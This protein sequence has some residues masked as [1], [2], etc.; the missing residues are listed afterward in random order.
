[1]SEL[2]D[3]SRTPQHA[4]HGQCP[5]WSR[6]SVA[7]L[8]VAFYR[9]DEQ[10]PET[11]PHS[12][13]ATLILFLNP[14]IYGHSPVEGYYGDG[15]DYQL[16]DGTAVAPENIIAFGW[17]DGQPDWMTAASVS[18]DAPPAAS[19]A[20][21]LDNDAVDRFAAALKA[22]LA[23]KRAEGYGGWHDT[24][25]CP[26]GRLAAQLR[27]HV[28]KGDP[29]DVGNLAM[30]LWSRGETTNEHEPAT[31]ERTERYFLDALDALL[32]AARQSGFILTT[33]TVPLQPLAMGH[34]RVVAQIRPARQPTG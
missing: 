4:L 9:P 6:S 33:E 28:R 10:T 19:S 15:P 12:D 26:A 27:D 14:S 5:P 34:Y 32:G 29:V 31:H 18:G 30:M 3:A 1:M 23:A 7:R 2:L 20:E 25:T 13:D 11:V 21:R 16:A 22:K 17:L 24:T 8:S